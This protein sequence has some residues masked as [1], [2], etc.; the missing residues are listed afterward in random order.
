MMSSKLVAGLLTGLTMVLAAAPSRAAE[1]VQQVLTQDLQV[2]VAQQVLRCWSPPTSAQGGKGIVVRLN[3]RLSID[4]RLTAMP[5]P[6]ERL[7][8][9]DTDVKV[10]LLA[11]T[12]A[13]YACAPYKLPAERYSLWKEIVIVFDPRSL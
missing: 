1:Q 5:T 13:V 10:W 4:G 9:S 8:M 2:L 12:K 7:D 11:A 6:A 3:I